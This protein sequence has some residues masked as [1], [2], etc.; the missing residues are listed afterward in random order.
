M[1]TIVIGTGVQA[2]FVHRCW[3]IFKERVLLT[4][5]LAL[6]S[7]VGLVAG[8]LV[9]VYKA[10]PTTPNQIAQTHLQGEALQLSVEAVLRRNRIALTTWAFSWFVLELG[11]TVITVVF[12]YRV[13]T[14]LPAH[15]G[16]FSTV[17][18]I[19]WVSVTPPL[20]LM[21]VIIID[22]YL[23]P[24]SP[25]AVSAIVV[26]MTGNT[27][28]HPIFVNDIANYQY[29]SAKFFALSLMINLV[30]QGHIRE[31][32]ERSLPKPS[33]RPDVV[34]SD[35]IFA[36]GIVSLG[37][38]NAVN[39]DSVCDIESTRFGSLDG[40]RRME[41]SVEKH[42]MVAMPPPTADSSSDQVP[43]AI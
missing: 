26:G 4:I 31:K 42:E 33:K 23:A 32:F 13:R 3:K 20:I 22:G 10:D 1:H 43:S 39:T 18:Q 29:N 41:G 15:D 5:P 16:I 8:I 11:M 27:I 2:F 36:N 30:G 7:L 37:S 35:A 17:W 21:I 25:T 34:I 9:V 28:C 12:L 40:H 19:L 24:G 6:L 14:G 38:P